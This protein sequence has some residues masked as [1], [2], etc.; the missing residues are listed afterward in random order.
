M[1]YDGHVFDEDESDY[2]DIDDG[3]YAVECARACRLE[4]KSDHGLE[5][6]D[7][8]ICWDSETLPAAILLRLLLIARASCNFDL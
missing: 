4:A 7:Q 5:K 8:P 3:S 1:C 2:T 6:S